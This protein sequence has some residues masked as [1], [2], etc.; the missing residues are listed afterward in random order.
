[1]RLTRPALLSAVLIVI[2]S[3]CRD[4]AS[5]RT[6][7][8]AQ[9]YAVP[10]R[11]T[12]AAQAVARSAPDKSFAADS[13]SQSDAL[14]YAGTD[15]RGV[16]HYFA[17]ALSEE[18]AGILRRA[19]GVASPS[20]LYIS[21]S[22]RAGLLKYDPVRKS[23]ATCYVNSYR[24]GFVS[25]RK[26]G[27]SW[28]E[29]ERRIRTMHRSSFRRSSLVASRSVSAMDPDVQAEVR[30]MLDAARSAGFRVHVMSTYRSPEQEALL[31]IEGGGRTHTLTSLHSYGRAIDVSIGDGNLR[32]PATRRS[33][34][35]FR[36]WVTRFRGGDFRILGG[37]EQSWDW[38]HVELPGE[39]IGFRS[40]DGAV[41]AGRACLASVPVRSCDFRPNLP[42]NP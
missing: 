35:A 16:P 30:Q 42:R 6:T 3:G 39:R 1:M 38:P 19:F 5:A 27:E 9:S 25:I 24:I 18:A 13:L 12:D 28:D 40:V 15:Q 33:W 17:R 22:T 23:C 11:P 14:D 4:D 20:H 2:A 37:P 8:A 26:P 10:S 36:R 29:L 32:N 41:A 31:M 7:A 34:V 21:D